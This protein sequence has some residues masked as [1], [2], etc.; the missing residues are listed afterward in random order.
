M[1]TI[2]TRTHV[3]GDL[4]MITGTFSNLPTTSG[5]E[6]VSYDGLLGTVFRAGGH[7][8][9]T[10][11]TGIVTNGAVTAG[12]ANITVQSVDARL[13][14]NEGEDVYAGNQFVGTVGAPGLSSTNIPIIGGA[15]VAVGNGE[16]ILKFG[17]KTGS[18]TLTSGDFRVNIDE[19]NKRIV[20]THG[21]TGATETT[22]TNSGRYWILG[23]R[24]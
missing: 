1:T 21:N 13:F 18:V 16:K 6:S 20:F 7:L 8:T 15:K 17:P 9:S 22:H 10:F 19:T 4:L 24:A 5:S 12:D 14:F 3:L 11:T 2:D 23:S